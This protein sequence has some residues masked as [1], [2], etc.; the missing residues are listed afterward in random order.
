MNTMPELDRRSFLS[1]LSGLPVAGVSA[2]GALFPGILFARA[3][4]DGEITIQ[5]IAYAEEIAG[6]SFSEAERER[7]LEG[8]TENRESYQ[9]LREVSLGNG[10]IPSTVFDPEM[11]S[12]LKPRLAFRP[13][14]TWKP[15]EIDTPASEEDLAFSTVPELSALLFHRQIRSVE[16]TRLYLRRLKKYGSV[17]ENVVTLTEERAMRQ[18]RRADEELDAGDWRGPLHGIPWGAKDLLSV[19]GY[20]TTWGAAPYRDQTL[21]D[22]AAVVGMLDAAGAVLVA[23]LTLGALAWGD[24][25]FGGKTKNPWNIDVGSS[26][27]S[28]GPGASVAAGLVGFAIGSETLGS[29]VSPSNRNGVTGFRPTFGRVSRRGAMT[30]SWTLDKLGPM[31]RSAE[32]CALV[33]SAIHGAEFGDPTTVTTPFSWPAERPVNQLRIGYL[34]AAFDAEYANRDADKESLSVLRD[35][36]AELIAIALP[37]APLDGLLLMLSAEAAA[38]FEELTRTGGTDEMV[39]QDLWPD[40]FRTSRFI[41]AVE[42]INASRARR[43]LMRKMQDV[44]SEIDVFISPTFGGNTLRVTNLTG[45]PSVTVPNRFAR[46]E[47]KPLSARRTPFSITF[48]GQLHADDDLLSVAA[49]FQ[50]R[51]Q[52]HR[53]RPP[54]G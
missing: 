49:A 13:E 25:W 26:G 28:A 16:L 39:R 38:A 51:T 42:Y 47:D 27:S 54:I 1:V 29:I 8:L 43:L 48:V 20:K 7:I 46:L 11:G 33:F 19:S 17:L 3:V 37:E 35:L 15:D 21:E 34:E 4:D 50:S 9:S 10:D 44:M 18:A 6:L 31:C 32:G 24:V 5:A 14:I 53:N 45:H 52:F 2:A 23:K 40:S 12:H 36:G 22:T 41:P 30:L